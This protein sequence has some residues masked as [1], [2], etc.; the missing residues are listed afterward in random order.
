[1]INTIICIGI[2]NK[3]QILILHLI[4]RIKNKDFK[5]YLTIMLQG[6][7]LWFLTLQLIFIYPIFIVLKRIIPP[8]I[9]KF[10]LQFFENRRGVCLRTNFLFV[11][12][13][14][15]AIKG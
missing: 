12:Q 10:H 11:Y 4:M 14:Q 15:Q 3:R 9:I 13:K 6:G 7:K 8:L 1:M 5:I 2:I